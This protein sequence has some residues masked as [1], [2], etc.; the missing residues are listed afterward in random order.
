[1]I[2]DDL[3]VLIIGRLDADRVY[4]AFVRLWIACA[5]E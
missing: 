4:I 1:M 5:I 3:T 2:N